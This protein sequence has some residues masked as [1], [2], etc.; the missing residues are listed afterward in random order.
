[1]KRG[2]KIFQKGVRWTYGKDSNL[3]FWF[4]NWFILRALRH[5]IQGPIFSELVNLKVKMLYPLTGGIGL[6]L[7]LIFL[8]QSSKNFR[9]FRLPWHPVEK[10]S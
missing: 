7:P 9:P 3:N 4:D 1:M 2:I 10:T 8:I 6:L 5:I